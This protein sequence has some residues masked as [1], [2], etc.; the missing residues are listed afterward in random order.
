[1]SDSGL[2]QILSSYGGERGALVP[3]LQQ[4]QEKLGYL[5]EAAMLEV[6][7]HLGV[8]EAT[9]YSVATFYAQFKLVP[10]GR[11]QVKV[12][13]GTACHVRGGPKI[14]E[15]A[16][17]EL[18]IEPG[19]TTADMEYSLDRVACFGCCALAPV[20][21]VGEQVYGKM[22]PKEVTDILKGLRE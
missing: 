8:D 3:I 17:R 14:L 21:K 7:R 19:G 20:V 5:P 16:E 12:C 2:T 11:H 18:G 10:T 6:A 4:I 22:R 15:A 1:M 13:C 9:V